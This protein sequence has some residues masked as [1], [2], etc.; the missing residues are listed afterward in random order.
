LS[1]LAGV[2]APTLVNWIASGLITPDRFGRGRGG[3]SIGVSGLLE[4]VTIIELKSAGF[5]MQAIRRA[6]ENLRALS[7]T[8]RPLADLTL[9]VYGRDLVWKDAKELAD[10]P[11]SALQKPG[12]RLML[13]PIGQQHQAMLQRLELEGLSAAAP[14]TVAVVPG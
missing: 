4:L 12:Q 7:G 3:H 10:T 14:D 1:R 9:L 2:P 11:I 13:L 6:V 8:T 5:S